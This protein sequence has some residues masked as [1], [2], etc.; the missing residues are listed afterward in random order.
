MR[1]ITVTILALLLRLS[2]YANALAN[3]GFEENTEQWQSWNNGLQI[4][5]TTARSGSAA[6]QLDFSRPESARG[7]GAHQLVE[8]NQAAAA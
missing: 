1:K 2:A 4:D 6:L 7:F 3:A 5:T 8:L